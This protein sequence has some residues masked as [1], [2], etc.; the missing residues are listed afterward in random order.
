MSAPGAGAASG[1][2]DSRVARSVV[3]AGLVGAG[4]LGEAEPEHRPA[5]LGLVDVDAAALVPGHLGHDGQAQARTGPAPG[6]RGPVE[7]VEDEVDVAVVDPRPVVPDDQGPAAS[8]PPRP[9]LRP[10]ST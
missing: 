1:L 7:A 10:G 3:V 8:R 2:D 9:P 5:A 6:A 4:D